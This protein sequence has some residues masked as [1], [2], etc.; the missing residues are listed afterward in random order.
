V[1]YG[2]PKYPFRIDSAPVV[3]NSQPD[4]VTFADGFEMEPPGLRLGFSNPFFAG[5]NPV[6][7]RVANEMQE[8]FAQGIH[9]PPV[10]LSGSCR[11]LDL[12]QLSEGQG[13]IPRVSV[14]S[15][16]KRS[17]RLHLKAQQRL[18]LVVGQA[19]EISIPGLEL[20]THLA[21]RGRKGRQH[22]A[23][24]SF[25]HAAFRQGGELKNAV[26]EACRSYRQYPET[27]ASI[28]EPVDHGGR[29][30]HLF[31]WRTLFPIGDP[32]P[33]L[34][35]LSG[36]APL[37]LRTILGKRPQQPTQTVTQIRQLAGC[38][39]IRGV[40][41][42]LGTVTELG[43]LGLHHHAAGALEGVQLAPNLDRRIRIFVDVLEEAV[44]PLQP[45]PSLFEE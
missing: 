37:P 15:V 43:H 22:L 29:H 5:F 33:G 44:Q 40:D 27:G 13:E 12:D 7:D 11:D 35:G 34:F 19:T 41:D 14:E 26:G 6:V 23:G 36:L 31:S 3:S 18:E 28:R 4:P 25:T 20:E 16:E 2:R 9:D 39:T 8:G 1:S 10:E 38:V 24:S 17:Q 30:T 42:I 45:V 32:L 21:Q